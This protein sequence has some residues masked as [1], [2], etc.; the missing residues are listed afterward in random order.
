[1]QI[2]MM[3]DLDAILPATVEF[4]YDE[5]SAE[6]K[7]ML[8]RY[9]GKE[10]T[11]ASNYKKRK[12]ERAQLNKLG[13]ALD[14]VRKD[15][16]KRLL[17]VMDNGDEDVPSFSDKI[18]TLVGYVKMISG[19]IDNG[20][21]EYEDGLRLELRREFTE[22][23]SAKSVEKLGEGWAK[24]SAN[25]I[26]LWAE[27]QMNR[28]RGAWLNVG[29]DKEAVFGEIDAELERCASLAALLEKS[30]LSPADSELTRVRARQRMAETFNSDEVISVI[31]ECRDAE[32]RA[33]ESAERERAARLAQMAKE[34]KPVEAPSPEPSEVAP[35][36]Q[37]V[38]QDPE[39]Y[40]CEMRFVGTLAA[41]QNLREYLDVNGDI[42]YEVTRQMEVINK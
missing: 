9:R 40:S 30:M 25:R 22:Y 23:L 36:A 19:E 12:D 42:K 5:L 34:V 6:L 4:N 10:R 28:K 15:V 11:D 16:K 31:S 21:K 13:T 14:N 7:Q 26:R 1:M 24:A 32:R 2:K 27:E 38:R 17:A 8:E 41:F 35:G 39:M 18:N 33:A 29:V 20:I 3:T 37:T